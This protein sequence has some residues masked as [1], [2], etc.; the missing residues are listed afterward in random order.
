MTASE[1]CSFTWTALFNNTF[2]SNWIHF[3]FCII[4]YSFT[5][6]FSL[7]YSWYCYNQ[8]WLPG[9]VLQKR[10]SYKFRKFYKKHLV[11]CKK[12]VP[13]NFANSFYWSCT[14]TEFNFI[15]KEIPAQMFSCEFYEISHNIFFKEPFGRLLLHQHLFC[16]PSYHN[17]SLFQKRCH[18]FFRLRIFS[19]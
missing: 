5:Y 19:V 6:Q 4:I 2:G 15:K 7:H 16:L 11:F 10:C 13:T 17:L 18:T 1:T 12:A 14:S 3:S 9:G 8:K